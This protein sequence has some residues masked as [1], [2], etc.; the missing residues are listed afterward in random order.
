MIE[1]NIDVSRCNPLSGNSYIKLPKELNQ[2][3]KG[4]INIQNI[5]DNKCLKWCLV[6]F[7]ILQTIFQEELKKLTKNLQ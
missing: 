6:R 3:R 4:L 1:Q 5:D 7:A 2:S